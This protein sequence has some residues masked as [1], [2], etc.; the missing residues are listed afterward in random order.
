MIS[1]GVTAFGRR[2]IDDTSA[3]MAENYGCETVYGDTDS[4]FVQFPSIVGESDDDARYRTYDLAIKAEKHVNG[5]SG[6]FKAPVFLEYEKTFQPFLLLGKKRYCA[7]KYE[8]DMDDFNLSYS[9]IEL[10]RR[11]N[12]QI[13]GKAQREYLNALLIDQDYVAALKTIEVNV[14]ALLENRVPIEQLVISKKLAKQTY[15]SPQIHV[16]LNERIRQRSPALAYAL[17]DRI[18]YV[19][20]MDGRKDVCQR[21]EDPEFVRAHPEIKL[22]IDYYLT[23]QLKTPMGRLVTPIVGELA[24]EAWWSRTVGGAADAFF[25]SS[26]TG[27]IPRMLTSSQMDARREH[28]IKTNQRKLMAQQERKRKRDPK[29]PQNVQLP[30]QSTLLSFF[31]NP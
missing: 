6:I 29:N 2:M 25:A 14:K 9:G 7:R 12:A 13:L 10:K 24:F 1:A 22:D 3:F 17:G 5:P 28:D 31:S 4:V 16:N 30:R 15:A 26:L 23:K 21:G 19:V 8:F 20:T 27:T 11:D 18:P